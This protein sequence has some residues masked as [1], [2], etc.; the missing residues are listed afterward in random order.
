MRQN[1]ESHRQDEFTAQSLAKNIL[2]NV[3]AIALGFDMEG[4][5]CMANR[6]ASLVL[7]AP[8]RECMGKTAKTLGIEECL[9]GLSPRV[10]EL[11]QPPKRWELRR[12][13]YWEW[14]VRRTL[15]LLVDVTWS[16]HQEERNA[17]DRLLRTLRH[18]SHNSLAPIRSIAGSLRT[19]AQQDPLP[20]DWRDDMVLGL[21]V[22]EQ[23]CDTLLRFTQNY[24]QLGNLPPPQCE[25]VDI[26]ALVRRA[27]AMETRL[28]VPVVTGPDVVIQADAAQL[29]QALINLIRNGADALRPGKGSVRVGWNCLDS[30][31][32]IW[33]RDTGEGLPEGEDCFVPFFTTK[34]GG[35]GIGLPLSRQIAESHGGRLILRKR[36][37]GRGCEALL[38]LPFRQ[39]LPGETS[40]S[41]QGCPDTDTQC[42]R[43]STKP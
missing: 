22:I 42:S 7:S 17:W 13:V 15:V 41:G 3:D 30:W 23:R 10:V 5:L 11:S 28:H 37:E 39:G 12:G 18:E 19:M 26:G 35:T 27:A 32:H 29:E 38:S 4:R 8:L 36:D 16:L 14:G 20:S 9:D 21:E 2:S 40:A 1:L 6:A 43:E 24:A 31:L 33:V 25:P 34:E